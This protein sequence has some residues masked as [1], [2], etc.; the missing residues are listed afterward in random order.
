VS[1]IFSKKV[2]H[3]FVN[4]HKTSTIQSYYFLISE[5]NVLRSVAQF[6]SA[7]KK[8]FEIFFCI[9]IFWS[10]FRFYS[11][12]LPQTAC[13]HLVSLKGS[14]Y[15]M[16]WIELNK[17]DRIATCKAL[18]ETIVKILKSGDGNAVANE[19]VHS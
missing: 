12:T 6:F 14:T 5:E 18:P 16:F 17:K 10:I 7:R 3:F 2:E 1:V 19:H 15:S 11:V 8:Y 4:N 13:Q 9:D